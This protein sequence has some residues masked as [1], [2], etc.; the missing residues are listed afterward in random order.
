MELSKEYLYE[1]N[2][3]V[4]L[5]CDFYQT[6]QIPS[7]IF[8]VRDNM[9]LFPVANVPLIEYILTNLLDQ[10]FRNVIIAGTNIDNIVNHVKTTK[11]IEH[12]NIRIFKS[13]GENTGD[14]FR[15]LHDLGFEFW[16][17]V[18]MFANHYTNIPL[19][20]LIK[21]HRKINNA[22]MT[23]FTHD[24]ET[25]DIMSHVYATI[26]GN[27]CHYEKTEMEK[28][29]SS[30][31]MNFLPEHEEVDIA[32]LSSG[33]TIAVVSN[34]V[35]SIF[36]DNF[37]YATFEDLIVGI[38]ASGIYDFKFQVVTQEDLQNKCTC[39]VDKV[40]G[41]EDPDIFIETCFEDAG[42]SSYYSKEIVTL[43]DYY[44]I[45]DDVLKLSSSVFKMTQTPNFLKGRVDKIHC[46]ENSVIGEKSSI[47]GN[48]KNCI[49]WEN[50]H[51]V[52][53]FCDYIIF[54]DGTMFD[55][56][57]LEVGESQRILK[58]QQASEASEQP[59]KNETF[60]DDITEYL[61]SILENPN[62]DQV[63]LDDVNKQISLLRIVWNASRNELIEAFAFFFIECVDPK[64]LDESVLKTTTF[65]AILAE[66]VSTVS[67]QE[68]LM[69]NM[70]W[71]LQEVSNV[72]LKAQIFFNYAYLFVE[73][74][75]VE[76][77]I[78][79]RYSKMYKN[80]TF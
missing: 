34:I 50:C 61:I 66:T 2:K 73:S 22:M 49:V 53:D 47:E 23:L 57:H 80:G 62:Y 74:N 40:N 43:L 77:S 39:C 6:I 54:T 76:K 64:N 48:L 33:P 42:S 21:R 36:A 18:V 29:D 63:N 41:C 70:R 4:L 60:F 13:S 5:I 25:N 17:L 32:T 68:L 7:S 27:L 72:D 75:I 8:E 20:K 67:E 71:N 3:I 37:D 15:E 38:L 65:F 28:V 46:I 56:F 35:F 31:I 52:E 1:R 24:A 11:F 58:Q 78:V 12:M 69:E 55:V 19:A 45:N 59:K 16:D 26:D 10:N 51:V 14:L 30:S 79:K 9:A 44:K